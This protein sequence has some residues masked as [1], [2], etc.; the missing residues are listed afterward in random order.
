MT[1]AGAKM[2]PFRSQSASKRKTG[3]RQLPRNA[4][5]KS[6][7]KDP[8]IREDPVAFVGPVTA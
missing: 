4:R 2:A 1:I 7:M 6:R 5:R 8:I 3:M